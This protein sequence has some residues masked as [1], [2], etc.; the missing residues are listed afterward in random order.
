MNKILSNWSTFFYRIATRRN[1]F[2]A[3]AGQLLFSM[4]IF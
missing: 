2:L 4:I 3:L 1:A